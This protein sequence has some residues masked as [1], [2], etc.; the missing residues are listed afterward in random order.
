M[1]PTA[2]WHGG[3][4]P[5][6]SCTPSPRVAGSPRW[7]PGPRGGR[8]WRDR[9]GA[10]CRD[11]DG[12]GS[13]AT[14]EEPTMTDHR[15]VRERLVHHW[16]RNSPLR[17]LPA[18]AWTRQRPTYQGARP[19]LIE[20]AL[21]RAQGRP[22]G[23]W[24]VFGASGAVRRD[25]PCGVTVAGVEL[26]AWRDERGCLI[27]GPGAC[28]HLGAPLAQGAV[29]CGQLVCR[30]H[31]L[32]VGSRGGGG[33]RALPA[34]DDGVLAWV[35]L[36]AAGGEPPLARP[37]VPARPPLS[38][39][40]HAVAT[41]TGVCEPEDIVANRLDPWHG[42]WF[43]PY[44]F[45]RLSVL[46]APPE[47]PAEAAGGPA[48]AGA[49][50]RFVVAV[51]FRVLPGFGVPVRAEF[52]CPAPRTVVMRITEGEGAGSVVETHATPLGRGPDGRPRTMVTE[53]VVAHSER[54]GFTL[55]RHAAPALRPAIRRAAL[56]LWR[57]DLA[58]AERRY[59]LR[60]A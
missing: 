42:A 49:D 8:G 17:P 59:Q 55:A 41:L 12:P 4:W 30:W 11:R 60:S 54:P 21:T 27:V 50:D 16:P 58:Y 34:H 5:G 22:A 45:G 48:A 33:W 20:A 46:S 39:S 1:L 3:D 9:G 13:T 15:A 29:D 36:D 53:A 32:R 23:N 19:A 44:S 10:A 14:E 52:T 31:G 40:V 57:D 37:V 51:T 25:R 2:S 18:E 6:T 38:R 35:R 28:P 56:R 47:V 26:V 7:T 24:F 43:H